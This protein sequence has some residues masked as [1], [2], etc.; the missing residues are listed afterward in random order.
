MYCEEAVV[1][2]SPGQSSTEDHPIKKGKQ[3]DQR[4]SGE[5]SAHREQVQQE[6]DADNLSGPNGRSDQNQDRRGQRDQDDGGRSGH[7]G[8][9]QNS[10]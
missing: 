8:R 9:D 5:Q 1:R 4:S 7:V 10:R 6:A 3:S 2:N